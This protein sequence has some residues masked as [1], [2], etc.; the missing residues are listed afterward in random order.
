MYDKEQ[1]GIGVVQEVDGTYFRL[2]SN[3]AHE[4]IIESARTAQ[5]ETRT[6]REI[7]V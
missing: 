4:H 6:A 2:E 3:A 7:I 5:G 1:A